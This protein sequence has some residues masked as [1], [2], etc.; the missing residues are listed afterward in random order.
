M[1]PLKGSEF[2]FTHPVRGATIDMKTEQMGLAFQFTHPVRGREL[3]KLDDLD[4]L[5]SVAIDLDGVVGE[6]ACGTCETLSPCH[7]DTIEELV[8]RRIAQR[9][10]VLEDD[11]LLQAHESTGCGVI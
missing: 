4:T 8:R 6:V 2:Q 10:V 1:P 9:R 5:E 7:G 11:Q 3:D